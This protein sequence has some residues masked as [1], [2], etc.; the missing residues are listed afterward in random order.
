MHQKLIALLEQSSLTQ[1]PAAIAELSGPGE[2][3]SLEGSLL[4]LEKGYS[5]RA[6]FAAKRG[7]LALGW[8]ELVTGLQDA[9]LDAGPR[10]KGRLYYRN[11]HVTPII[12]TDAAT[13]RVL[14]V[15]VQKGPLTEEEVIALHKELGYQEN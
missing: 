9:L 12:F 3:E 5:I 10:A 7:S 1:A 11:P 15:I 2:I 14:G 6:S 13:T 4:E 8:E